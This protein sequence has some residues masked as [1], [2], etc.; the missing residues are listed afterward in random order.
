MRARGGG[1][2][3]NCSTWLSASHRRCLGRHLGHPRRVSGAVSEG[4]GQNAFFLHHLLQGHSD[5]GVAGVDLVVLLAAGGGASGSEERGGSERRRCSLGAPG[6]IHFRGSTGK[7][8][9][10]SP[11]P[12]T[13]VA[14]S[15]AQ[16]L[17]TTG[18][19]GSIV[20]CRPNPGRSRRKADRVP[21][22]PHGERIEDRSTRRKV[23]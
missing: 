3:H 11:T 21:A 19:C 15:L 12:H 13:P 14:D 5:S 20:S 8:F 16:I 6:W 2:A 17:R 1:G 23:L 9:R 7:G 18:V 22:A 4:A 10:E